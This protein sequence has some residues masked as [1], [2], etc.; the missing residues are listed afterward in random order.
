M[1]GRGRG[2]VIKSQGRGRLLS[3]TANGGS[4]YVEGVGGLDTGDP[5]KVRLSPEAV[6]MASCG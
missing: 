2:K 5:L 6:K 4:S 1:K 3:A